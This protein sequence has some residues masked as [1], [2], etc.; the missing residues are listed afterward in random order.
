MADKSPIVAMKALKVG[1]IKVSNSYI[2][3]NPDISQCLRLRSWFDSEGKE[4]ELPSSGLCLTSSMKSQSRSMYSYRV[5]LHDVTRNPS[6]GEDK[7]VYFNIRASM[8]FLDPDHTMS[9][10][11][12]KSCN[13]KVTE[14]T[15]WCARCQKDE[16]SFTLRKKQPISFAN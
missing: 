5:T 12:C 8:T 9:Y 11:A 1:N 6:L 13:K 10:R 3:V 15:G 4:T 14:S 7:A 2:R 16:E